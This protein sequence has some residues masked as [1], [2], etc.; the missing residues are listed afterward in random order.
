MESITAIVAA[1]AA[2]GLSFLIGR[3][4][5]S[6]KLVVAL[7]GAACGLA[8]SIS[9]RRWKSIVRT[10]SAVRSSASRSTQSLNNGPCISTPRAALHH[11][12]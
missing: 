8:F 1:G 10:R 11:A 7:M 9:A 12:A 6:T 3:T 5:V 4:M 2:F